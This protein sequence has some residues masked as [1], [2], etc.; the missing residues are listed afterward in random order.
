LIRVGAARRR[1]FAHP[2]LLFTSS[3]DAKPGER[4]LTL[5]LMDISSLNV[6][7]S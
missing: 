4:F 2:T 7:R 5:Y 3:R 6:G 1:A